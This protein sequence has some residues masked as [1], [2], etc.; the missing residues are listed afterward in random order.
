MQFLEPSSSLAHCLDEVRPS[1]GSHSS[2][3]GRLGAFGLNNI[4]ATSRSLGSPIA[5]HD[6]ICPVVHRCLVEPDFDLRR[7]QDD[8][9]YRGKKLAFTETVVAEMVLHKAHDLAFDFRRRD[10]RQR[11]GFCL[12]ARERGAR[13]IIAPAL[14]PLRGAARA[15]EMAAIV[16][17]LARK[18]RVL[19]GRC[20]T[21]KLGLRLKPPSDVGENLRIDDRG[22]KALVDLPFV[23]KPSVIDRVRENPIEM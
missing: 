8:P 20:L 7:R 19:V 22:M 17:E 16:I 21:A 18:D 12:I 3:D 11:T 2:L 13:D 23:T 9:I 10:P 5:D 6:T 4:T 14:G 1:P 15:H